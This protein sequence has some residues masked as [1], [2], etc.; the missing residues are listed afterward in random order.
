MAFYLCDF[1]Q[2]IGGE[3]D[4]ESV[5]IT[6]ASYPFY[7]FT[8]SHMPEIIIIYS[9]T[10]NTAEQTPRMTVWDRSVANPYG[11]YDQYRDWYAGGFGKFCI[12][13]DS[14]QNAQCGLGEMTSN[15]NGYSNGFDFYMIQTLTDANNQ[16]YWRISLR[17]PSGIPGDLNVINIYK[18]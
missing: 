3:Y 6:D 1:E 7:D 4:I 15:N 16:K 5:T 10:T 9:F 17:I 14:F 12:T 2:Q 8:L 18:K 11:T 13:G